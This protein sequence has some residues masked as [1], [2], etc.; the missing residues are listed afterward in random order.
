M[1]FS[2]VLASLWTAALLVA[3]LYPIP[4]VRRWEHKQ[5]SHK[6]TLV[7]KVAHMILFAGFG[8]LW[9]NTGRSK[10]PW[11][12]VLCIGIVLAVGTE[13]L[14]GLP[15]ID[16]DPDPL[17]ALADLLGL[18]NACLFHYSSQSASGGQQ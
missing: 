15:V 16:R 3:C 11:K 10:P 12:S 8:T 2:K 1:L 4:H 6:I 13:V 14:Q 5:P 9:L 18:I 7:D 17:D